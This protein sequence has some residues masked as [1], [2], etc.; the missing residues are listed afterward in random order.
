MLFSKPA[1]A[2]IGYELH[3][4][5]VVMLLFCDSC[6]LH[7]NIHLC[8]TYVHVTQFDKSV[9]NTVST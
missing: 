9:V 1:A 8:V 2:L 3:T 4:N 6:D 7:S 5:V